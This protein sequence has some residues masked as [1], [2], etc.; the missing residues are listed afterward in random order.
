MPHPHRKTVLGAVF[1]AVVE[2]AHAQ[3]PVIT[4]AE[5]PIATATL[6]YSYTLTASGGVAPYT[7]RLDA[8][9]LPAAL[10][11]NPQTGAITGVAAAGFNGNLTFRVTGA[12]TFFATKTFLFIVRIETLNVT[13]DSLSFDGQIGL[14]AP[15]AQ[16]FELFTL[17][18]SVPFTAAAIS[19][20]GWLT[21]TP[22][23][24][25]TPA[26]PFTSRIPAVTMTVSVN[27][28]AASP[29][30]HSG[31]IVISSPNA[32]NS[33]R[34]VQVTLGARAPLR[35]GS[36][37]LPA[38]IAG[39]AYRFVLA[40]SGGSPPYTWLLRSGSLQEGLTLNSSSGVI[41]GTPLRW[42]SSVLTI[43]VTD[44][45]QTTAAATLTLTVAAGTGPQINTGG[46]VGGGLGS[47]G[48][49]LISPNA[50]VSIFGEN[51]AA[52][53]V[54]RAAG[55]PDLVNGRLP[56]RLAGICVQVGSQPASLFFV[57]A[58]QLNVQVPAVA[59][60]GTAPVQVTRDCG[61]LNEV[62]SNTEMVAVRAASPE[63]F[64]F[65]R[66]PDGRNPIVAVNVTTGLLV[67][68]PGL[69]AGATFAR[70]RPS[71]VVTLYATGFG[72]TEPAFAAGE[73][74]DRAGAAI[75]RARVTIG[76]Q[77]LSEREVLYAGVAPLLAGV[78]Q[79]NLQLPASLPD[80]DLP[81]VVRLGAFVAPT[82]YLAVSR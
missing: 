17:A 22:T 57:S 33:P 26:N 27:P 42:G 7:W 41:G 76:N 66:N 56:V 70:A 36:S 46:V 60:G 63:F 52:P 62:R 21:V 32:G 65:V 61:A 64:Y 69:I 38:G 6:P 49:R 50:I 67:G 12:N 39:N 58:G 40:A 68:A 48:V 44:N 25:F 71:D 80:G 13:P 78:Y 73:L 72:V 34:M 30:T 51:F 9:V 8:G 77:E 47:P 54:E 24:G 59:A 28:A 35:I 31:T 15:P 20:G 18:V 14:P 11:L 75:E 79:L 29:G 74:P 10:S 1:F 5:I 45:V 4:T 16:T 81:V 82:G 2:I 43:Q 23:Q 37:S 53:G 3:S 55:A 19:V